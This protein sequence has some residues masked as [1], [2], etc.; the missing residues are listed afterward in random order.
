MQTV[1]CLHL[2]ERDKTMANIANQE[3]MRVVGQDLIELAELAEAEGL[4]FVAIANI[5]DSKDNT[6]LQKAADEDPSLDLDTMQKAHAASV[7]A[8]VKELDVVN[9]KN[10]YD[11][12][13]ADF[14]DIGVVS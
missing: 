2:K 8:K 11:K 9:V 12:T 1:Y 10:A 4:K 7:T 14:T 3:N 5:E 13:V 6:E